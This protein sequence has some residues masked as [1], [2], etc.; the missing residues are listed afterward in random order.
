MMVLDLMTVCGSGDR[1]AFDALLCDML[2][3][4]VRD[5][6]YAA[7]GSFIAAYVHRVA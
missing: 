4:E 1:A 3:F 6:I 7:A 5:R 2:P